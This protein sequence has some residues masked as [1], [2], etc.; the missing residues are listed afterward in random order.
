M[1]FL[2]GISDPILETYENPKLGFNILKWV[3]TGKFEKIPIYLQQFP[4]I[5]I[6]KLKLFPMYFL[7]GFYIVPT[8]E[9]CAVGYFS[10]PY[11]KPL[12]IPNC[13]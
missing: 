6:N 11:W 13:V 7:L 9:N 12:K 5:G 3:F 10:D 2:L 4:N 1:S 8:L